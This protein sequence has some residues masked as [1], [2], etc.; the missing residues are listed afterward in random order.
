MHHPAGGASVFHTSFAP[1]IRC[2]KLN[3]DLAA[4]ASAENSSNIKRD[5]PWD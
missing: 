2:H 1:V 5:K 4:I 3:S